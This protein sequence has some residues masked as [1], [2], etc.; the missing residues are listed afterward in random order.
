MADG[1]KY[2]A[3]L[4][5]FEWLERY[6]VEQ[7]VT[8]RA[9]WRALRQKSRRYAHPTYDRLFTAGLR[10]QGRLRRADGRGRK[11]LLRP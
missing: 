2:Q 3:G 6:L 8:D 1:G 4:A 7:G 10:A 11:S 5:Y 9:L